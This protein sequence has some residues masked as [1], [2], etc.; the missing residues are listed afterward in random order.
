MKWIAVAACVASSAY[1]WEGGH[2]LASIV[3][4]LFGVSIAST[5]GERTE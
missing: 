4:F 1:L 5:D 3:C 2:I